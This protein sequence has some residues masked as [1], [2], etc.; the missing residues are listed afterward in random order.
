MKILNRSVVIPVISFA[1]A[2]AVFWHFELRGLTVVTLFVPAVGLAAW[3]LRLPGGLAATVLATLLVWF[4]SDPPLS[5]RIQSEEFAGRILI[6]FAVNLF[7]S[8]WMSSQRR[9][10]EYQRML[11]ERREEMVRER[12]T[13]LALVSHELR[14]P[15]ANIVGWTHLLKQQSPNDRRIA[16]A[17]DVILRNAALQ[18]RLIDDLLQA[19]RLRAGKLELTRRPLDIQSLV[20]EEIRSISPF[21]ESKRISLHTEIEP[22]PFI[23][24]DIDRMRQVISNLLIN[25]IKFTPEGGEVCACVRCDEK[26]VRAEISDSGPGISADQLPYIFDEFRQAKT[27]GEGLGLGLSIAKRLV[28]MHGGVIDAF[29]R[30]NGGATFRIQLPITSAPVPSSSRRGGRA[31]STNAT[32]P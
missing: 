15:L 11:A 3:H 16:A 18:N 13:F 21:A 29:N 30:E 6:L 9:S 19:A 25:A 28:E 7:T 26:N 31:D 27:G 5:F 8:L 1:A 23:N 32:L 17:T 14:T 2:V 4:L 10:S 24:G 12:E 20:A 22:V